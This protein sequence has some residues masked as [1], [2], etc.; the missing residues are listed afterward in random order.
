MPNSAEILQQKFSNSF[1]LPFQTV[2]PESV[3]AEVLEAEEVSYRNRI[4]NPF[5][6]I[7]AF[8]SQVL[9]TDK[10]NRNAVS[11]V[12]AWLAG[13]GQK[14]PSDNTG[15]YT[16]AK[17]RLPEGIFKRLFEHTGQ[18]LE[19]QVPEV[20][21]W[22]GRQVKLLDGSNV[23]MPDTDANQKAYP[24]HSN[25]KA[26]CGFPLAKLVVMFSLATGAAI[27]VLIDPFKVSE[28]ELARRLYASLEPGDI[29]LA[30]RAYGTYVDLACVIARGADAVF[31][32]HQGRLSD[33]RRGKRLGKDDHLVTWNK[34]PKPPKHM[35]AQAFAQL[36]EFITVRQIRFQ[37]VQPG[38]RTKTIIVVTTLLD[39]KIYTKAQLAELYRLRWT[40]EVDLKHLK[41]TLQLEIL[42]GKSPEMVR[43]EL[44]VH[45]LA[46]NL[47]RSLMMQAAQTQSVSPLRLSLQ[48]TRQHFRNFISVLVNTATHLLPNL[49]QTL[50]QVLVRTLLPERPNRSEPRVRKRRPKA[51]PLMT[52]PRSTLKPNMAT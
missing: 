2:L 46:Y 35:N 41:T 4:F 30:D 10:S 42:R 6:T 15:G 27:G 7:W 49:L 24:Q 39:A 34:P 3:I 37:V 13:T 17:Q 22:C 48:G 26:G 16:Q 1:G 36:P 44:Y 11:R 38:Y 18:Q 28:L 45:L 23:S 50:F 43:K 8:L 33:F 5:V 12:I 47:L 52:K 9:D 29:A 20:Q 14:V 51:F 31:R 19:Q 21:L 32:C 40:V 25:Q